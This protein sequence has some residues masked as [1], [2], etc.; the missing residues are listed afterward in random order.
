MLTRNP[1]SYDLRIKVSQISF[2]RQKPS[3]NETSSETQRANPSFTLAHQQQNHHDFTYSFLY[4]YVYRISVGRIPNLCLRNFRTE[5]V[6][7]SPAGMSV[8]RSSPR[9]EFRG[10]VIS[11]MAH[12]APCS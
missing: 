9:N 11:E 10:V 5:F 4:F 2:Y 1:H 8:C 7:S 3:R 12:V 6:L